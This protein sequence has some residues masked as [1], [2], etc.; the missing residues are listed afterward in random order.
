[1]IREGDGCHQV[2]SSIT[3]TKEDMGAIRKMLR[4]EHGSGA[5][6]NRGGC[7]SGSHI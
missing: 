5:Q 4:I 3:V 2:D 6:G 1:M 7:L